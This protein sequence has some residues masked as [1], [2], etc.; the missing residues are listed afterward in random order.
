MDI[1]YEHQKYRKAEEVKKTMEESLLYAV[2]TAAW[3]LTGVTEES[4][5]VKLHTFQESFF[6]AWFVRL[7]HAA[8][9]EEQE[10]LRLHLPLMAMLTEDGG[11]FFYS[12]IV[13]IG[14]SITLKQ[15]WH[16]KKRYS[17]TG[18]EGVDRSFL[19][20]FLE[21]NVSEIITNHNQIA[22]QYGIK[23]EFSAPYF[24]I[25]N[26]EIAFPM[27]FVVFQGWPILVG[28]TYY[29]NCMDASAFIKRIEEADSS[30]LS[31]S[32]E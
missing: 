30:D 10:K 26:E 5:E 16:E 18:E 19:K 6:R 8:V 12:E 4:E 17:L 31:F 14:G 3:E 21:E 28:E 27:V 24:L 32:E 13:Q 25:S 22:K 23:Y 1:F 11:Y 2:K 15:R 29:E 7:G 9:T 20:E